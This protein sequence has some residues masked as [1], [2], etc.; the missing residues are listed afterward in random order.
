MGW[1]ENGDRGSVCTEE[2]IEHLNFNPKAIFLRAL[3]YSFT[4]LKYQEP[5][6]SLQMLNYATAN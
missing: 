6:N 2:V 1:K 4:L 5:L 3:A